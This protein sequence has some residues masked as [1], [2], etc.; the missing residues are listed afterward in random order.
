MIKLSVVV[1]TLNRKNSLKTTLNSIAKQTL[2]QSEFEVIVVDNGSTDETET[3]VKSF[4]PKIKNFQYLYTVEP[5]LHVGRHLG[6]KKSKSS[7]L[8]YTDDDIEAFPGWLAAIKDTFKEDKK[9]CLVGGKN[10]PK[11]EV[12]PPVWLK[13]IWS[14][15]SKYGKAY[16]YLSISDLGNKVKKINPYYI[17][18]CNFSV[19]KS[20]LI[21]SEGFHPDGMPSGLTKYRGDGESYIARFVLSKGYKSIY[22]PQASIFHLISKEKMTIDYLCKKAYMAGVSESYAK[23]RYGADDYSAKVQAKPAIK[24]RLRRIPSKLNNFLKKKFTQNN[25]KQIIE[26]KTGEFFWKGFNY[27]Q[28]KVAKDKNLLEW[29]TKKNY[30]D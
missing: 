28:E 18:G 6:L 2:P 14:K 5:G 12:D 3:V 1:P 4:H 8:V 27:H 17:W 15:K 10:L 11:F 7:I 30:L 29:V 21:E 16:S 13:E 26:E 20:I 22:N 23:I 25:Q 24:N 9:T 19:R